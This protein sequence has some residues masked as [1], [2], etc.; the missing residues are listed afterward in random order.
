[1]GHFS[2]KRRA[3]AHTEEESNTVR[4]DYLREYQARMEELRREPISDYLQSRK[5]MQ[6]LHEAR[7]EA[8]N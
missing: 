8:K 7:D 2:H 4:T 5:E 1:M 6:E 3:D